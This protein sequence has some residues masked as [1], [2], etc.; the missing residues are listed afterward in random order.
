M[1]L[2]RALGK[3]GASL[4]LMNEGQTNIVKR[5]N[6]HLSPHVQYQ[7]YPL[8]NISSSSH[9]LSS[10]N[11]P[12]TLAHPITTGPRQRQ[13]LVE[14]NK[15]CRRLEPF[16]SET[17]IFVSGLDRIFFYVSNVFHPLLL[18]FRSKFK[19]PYPCELIPR[20][21][22]YQYHRHPHTHN[23]TQQHLL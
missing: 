2:W 4:C 10:I 11:S 3:N 22:P 14:H 19:I 8:K 16:R 9:I 12:S 5:E 17:S 6:S 18:N 1:R 7:Q 23:N 20:R 15:S 21:N 13:D